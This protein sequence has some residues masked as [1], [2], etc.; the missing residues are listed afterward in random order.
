[1]NKLLLS[2]S[3]LILLVLAGILLVSI[4][5]RKRRRRKISK[6]LEKVD[7]MLGGGRITENDAQELKQAL[8]AAAFISP[9]KSRPDI[10]ILAV[11]IIHLLYGFVLGTSLLLNPQQLTNLAWQL[12]GSKVLFFYLSNVPNMPYQWE[13]FVKLSFA[14]LIFPFAFGQ[15]AG[16]V[17]LLKKRSRRARKF[18]IVFSVLLLLSL[19]GITASLYSTLFGTVSIF[20]PAGMFKGMF[21][22]AVGIYSLWVL[23]FREGAAEYFPEKGN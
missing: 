7:K 19:F 21:N 11:G 15:V 6:E 20:P 10:H 23:F 17:F 1:M 2:P 8:G 16:A 13:E 4:I 9:D 14:L 22:T 5:S 18:I 3:L 12:P